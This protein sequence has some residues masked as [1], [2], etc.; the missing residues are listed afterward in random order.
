MQI[1][2][3]NF[4]NF[5]SK[6]NI[7][8]KSKPILTKT[9]LEPKIDMFFK[10]TEIKKVT[11]DRFINLRDSFA[12]KLKP[13]ALNMY[14]SEWNFYINSTKENFEIL[15]KTRDKYVKIWQ[16]KTFYNKFLKIKDID[17]NKNERKQLKYIL[18][19]FEEELNTGDDLNKLTDKENKIAKKYNSYIPKI[20]GK[21]TTKAEINKI[22]ETESNPEIRKK[23][24]EAS[25]QGGD[26]IAKDLQ[27]LVKKRNKYAKK[28]GYSNFFEYKL[29][30]YFEVDLKELED[31]LDN[32]YNKSKDLIKI[33]LTETKK[34]LSEFFGISE[35]DLKSYHYGFLT[36]NNPEKK[37]NDFIKTKEQIVDIAKKTYQGMGYDIE[38]LEKNGNLTL[39]L[40][41]RE[42][43]NTHGFCFGIESGKDARILANLTNNSKSLDTLNHEL[44]HCIYTLNHSQDLSF[45]DKDEYPAMTEAVAMMMQDLQKRENILNNLVD[46]NI[47]EKY[48]K[49]FIND[50]VKF[51][52]KALTLINF[53]KEMYKNPDQDLKKLWHDMKVKYQMRSEKED[54][55]N[56]W[57]II[58]HFLSHPAYYQNYFRATIIKAQIYNYLT[59]KLGNLTENPNTAKVL[60][61]E[62]L[63]YG[64]SLEEN[65]LI[66]NMTGK[67][68]SVDDFINSLKV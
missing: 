26:L 5:N 14:I 63:Q 3:I 51:I 66:E 20:D 56:G 2:K 33:K 54:L 10:S 52:V 61:E 29:K 8:F 65:E 41:P 31:L 68:L 53:E 15:S 44:G 28:Q 45:F 24:Y 55:D 4:Y 9:K 40:F 37:V 64:K 21:K 13:I 57:A 39:D 46:S 23:A 67:K 34:E 35:E 58:P 30:D 60:K 11:M 59:S 38:N 19:N 25:I 48:K 62:L 22:L 47:L 16:N 42:N 49:T 18:K 27:E 43:K 6:N 17:L 32:V 12:E 36:E 1:S 7:N 50:E